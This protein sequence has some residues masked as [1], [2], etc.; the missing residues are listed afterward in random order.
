MKVG[1][2]SFAHVHAGAY[3]SALN[4]IPHVEFAGIYDE[5]EA[6][7]AEAAEKYGVAHFKSLDEMLASDIEAVVICSTNADHCHYTVKAAEA[8]KHVLV[9][10]PI[11]TTIED[12]KQ[13]I[14]ACKK[15]NVK[16][17]IAFPVRY[18]PAMVEAK[19]I[20]QS[21]QLGRI[22]AI[23]GTNN[24][25]MPGG[26]FVE[27][28]KSGGG[29]VM[30]HTV[31]VVDI[32][33]WML[34][35]EFEEIYAEYDRLIYD[36]PSEDC[37]MLTMELT[38]NVFATLDTSW[39]RPKSYPTWGGV[40]LTLIGTSGVLEMDAFGQYYNVYRDEAT[41]AEWA[42]FGGNMDYILVKDFVDACINDKPV[43]ITGEDGLRALEVALAAYESGRI[44]QPVKIEDIR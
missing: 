24:G 4:G 33:R 6:R 34:G 20:V 17:Q 23:K 1:M 13:M 27:K 21:G 30:D 7:G 3:A 39:N 28:D 19:R 8:K 43:K 44:H 10:K 25:S 35:L 29:A 26:W 14:E 12:A 15:H 36:I 31:H 16:L 41:K 42:N 9:E 37:G 11:A 38:G 18:M 2:I 22:L 5:D 40:T 32:I